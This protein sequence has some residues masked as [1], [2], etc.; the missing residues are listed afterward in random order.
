MTD[1]PAQSGRVI[2]LTAVITALT[3]GLVFLLF[4]LASYGA[5]NSD[6]ASLR[7]WVAKAFHDRQLLEDPFQEGSTSIGGHQWNDC[8][9]IVMAMDQRGDPKR[10]ALSPILMDFGPSPS[11]STNPCAVLKAL[12]DGA[13]PNDKLYYYDRYVHGAVVMLRYL[14]PHA[15]LKT[16]RSFYRDVQSL[17]LIFS[18]G[19][20]MVGLVRGQNARVFALLGVTAFAFSR[21]F[22]LESFSQSLGHGP[23]D[24][25][26]AAYLLALVAMAFAPVGLGLAIF[27][28]ALFGA[29]TIILELFTGGFQLGFAMAIGLAPFVV[30]PGLRPWTVA[31]C[32]GS[33]FVGAGAL[34][35]ILKMF[36]VV[37]IAGHGVATDAAGELMRLTIFS[38]QGTGLGEAMPAFIESIGSLAGGMWL[39]SAATL[40]VAIAGGAYGLSRILKKD[41]NRDFREKALLLAISSLIMPAWCLGFSNLMILHAWFTD[42]ILVWMIAVGFGLFLMA[43]IPATRG[44]RDGEVTPPLAKP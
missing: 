40:L 21:Y 1:S 39:L 5:I 38:W 8:L 15:S 36:A 6:P 14:A 23:A 2:L 37:L 3:G 7:P 9:I 33:A 19:L 11:V 25:L 24:S 30:R 35:Y 4:V 29:L 12:D 32:L 20:A 22:G 27:A 17:L 18:L 31:A 43:L 44:E 10:L 41:P 28:A 34:L 13:V 26:L 16:I 42:R